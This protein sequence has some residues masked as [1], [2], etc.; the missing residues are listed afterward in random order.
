MSLFFSF[1]P[2]CV[3][4]SSQLFLVTQ[5]VKDI[6][7]LWET[8]VRSLGRQDP[9]KKGKATHS[10]ILAWRIPWTE[11][12]GGLH[13][14]GSQRV[15]GTER[16][17]LTSLHPAWYLFLSSFQYLTIVWFLHSWAPWISFPPVP[18]LFP[19]GYPTQCFAQGEFSV[20]VK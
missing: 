2:E 10:S 3:T 8:W 17:S 4:C 20:F 6:L 9:L 7:E 12:P 5:T 1:F 11:E 16:L 19:T 13:S 14:M 18:A 15:G